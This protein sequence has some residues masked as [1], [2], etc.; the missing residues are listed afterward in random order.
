MKSML[1]FFSQSKIKVI[2]ASLISDSITSKNQVIVVPT[3]YIMAH[4]SNS[5]QRFQLGTSRTFH[6][7]EVMNHSLD[8]DISLT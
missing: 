7:L 3:F 5:R 6:F 4:Y 1:W 8:C 2:K